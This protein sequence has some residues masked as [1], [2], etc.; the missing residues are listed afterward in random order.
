M[1]FFDGYFLDHGQLQDGGP[2]RR[3]GRVGLRVVVQ[4]DVG[5]VCEPLEEER[6]GLVLLL[7]G[8]RLLRCEATVV[9]EF[10]VEV[11]PRS[12]K[13]VALIEQL[14]CKFSSEEKGD[15]ELLDSLEDFEAEN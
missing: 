9:A 6:D 4:L 2:E 5:A 11:S 12:D 8:E 10:E 15:S 7:L 13:H 1:F 14:E 3:T